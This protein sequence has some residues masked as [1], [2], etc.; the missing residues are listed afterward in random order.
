MKKENLET[1]IKKFNEKF[2]LNKIDFNNSTYANCKTPF[3][4]YCHNH[5]KNGEE[6]GYYTTTPDKLLIQGGCKYCKRKQVFNTTDFI[7]EAKYIHKD[8]FDYSNSLYVDSHCC[9]SIKCNKCGNIFYQT[10][11]AHLNKEG[12]PFCVESKMEKEI[13]QF[14]NENKIEFITQYRIDEIKN[15][16]YDFYLPKYNTIIECQGEQHF[17]PRTF[18]GNFDDAINNFKS[19]V[20]S[21]KIK[22]DT[23]LTK[24]INII[25]Y[26]NKKT[27]HK[28][29]KHINT[30]NDFY[31]DKVIANSLIDLSSI[32]IK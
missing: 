17:V 6:H 9:I 2:P 29:D 22:F 14:L 16:P 15:K 28:E 11:N 21:D 32:L 12:C 25:Y 10:P 3:T 23:A 8:N 13:T 24:S 19:T 27:F 1:Y 31:Y 7:R 20:N 30:S 4:V 18:G 26:I 5:F